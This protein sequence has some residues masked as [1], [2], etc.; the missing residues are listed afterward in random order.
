M[1]GRIGAVL[2][3]PLTVFRHQLAFGI[4]VRP[5][6]RRV[7]HQKAHKRAFGHKGHNAVRLIGRDFQAADPEQDHN[8]PQAGQ[9]DGKAFSLG[10]ASENG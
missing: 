3:M 5:V 7:V 6:V 4:H 2:L 9:R 10:H 1:R 8:E